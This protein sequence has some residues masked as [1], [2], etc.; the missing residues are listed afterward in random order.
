MRSN[1]SPSVQKLNT[2]DDGQFRPTSY[3]E[4][5]LTIVL[6]AIRLLVLLPVPQFICNLIGLTFYDAFQADIKLSDQDTAGDKIDHYGDI[7]VCKG[8][9]DKLE[10]DVH[11]DKNDNC[12][13]ISNGTAIGIDINHEEHS[14]LLLKTH[15]PHLCF[16]V[17]TRGLFPELVRRNLSHNLLT[18]ASS[19]LRDYSFEIVTDNN[20]KSL[21]AIEDSRVRQIVVPSDYRS[22][23]GAMFKARA[24]Q[25]ALEPGTSPLKE[26]AY[27]VHLDE[28]TLLTNNSIN[29]ILNFATNKQHSFGQGL[30]VYMNDQVVN[31]ITTMADSIRVAEDMGKL[32]FTLSALGKPIFGWK[33]SFV[34]TRCEAEKEVTFDHGPDGSI[35]EDCYFAMIAMSRG[36]SF[37][38]IEGEML[39][40]SPFTI[41]DIIKQRKRWIQGFWLV[42]HSPKIPIRTKLF[43]AMSLYGWSTMPLS[44]VSFVLAMVVTLPNPLWI[45]LVGSF[46]FAESLYM[47]IFGLLKS[48]DLKKSVSRATL[49]VLVIGQVMAV[50]LN[51]IIENIA[52]CWGVFTSKH[53]FYIVSKD[54]DAHAVVDL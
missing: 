48:Y 34:V 28:E 5:I 4:T 54:T 2:G 26:G 6:M 15:R 51:I 16:R 10:T 18:C 23:T 7:K 19:S 37:N 24:L 33:G 36:Y 11:E 41:Q 21:E 42:V 52:V 22:S 39:E 20:L 35:A 25:Y 44:T 46:C 50:F 13:F 30:I 1:G 17:V 32:R 38:F 12:N 31:W 53:H 43:L 29:G 40:K 45:N 8:A 27:I 3:Y 14:I 47:Y 49:L 9:Y